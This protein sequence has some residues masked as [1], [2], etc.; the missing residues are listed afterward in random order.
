MEYNVYVVKNGCFERYASM[1]VFKNNI[2]NIL[3]L[4]EETKGEELLTIIRNSKQGSKSYELIESVIEE[5]V[6]NLSI[7]IINLIEIFE[8]DIIGIGGSFV[9]FED[10]LLERLKKKINRDMIIQTAVLGNDAGIIG[11]TL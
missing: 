9:Y 5:Y 10:I 2:K 3:K 8:P 1:K 4:D 11:A 6:E 7:G